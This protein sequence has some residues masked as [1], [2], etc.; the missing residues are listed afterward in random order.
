MSKFVEKILNEAY[1]G[2]VLT[3]SKQ[4]PPLYHFTSLRGIGMILR[5]DK[6][7]ANIAEWPGANNIS[8]KKVYGFSTKRSC[9]I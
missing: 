5:D 6:I 8:G 3:E 9:K 1:W 4:V 2:T 7:H